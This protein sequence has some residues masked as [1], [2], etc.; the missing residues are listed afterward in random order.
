MIIGFTGTKYSGKDTG[1]DYLV[2]NYGFV[3]YS[4]AKPLKDA[5]K[6]LFNFDD[7]QLYTS[8][9]EEVDDRWG[10]SPRMVLQFLGTDLLRNNLEKL[11]P[12]IGGDFWIKLFS[13]WYKKQPKGTR[14]VISDIRFEN[15]EQHV[16]KNDGYLIR[17]NRGKNKYKDMHES[18][19]GIA[20][21]KVDCDIINDKDKQYYYDEID[22]FMKSVKVSKTSAE[23]IDK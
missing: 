19:K 10:V 20:K 3:K 4:M 22:K 9:K 17:A 16:H 2:K 1:A 18:E 8:K 11:L 12:G 13:L 14:V 7:E 23:D 15:E 5:C 6:V 21:L